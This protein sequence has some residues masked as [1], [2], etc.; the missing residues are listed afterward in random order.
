ML[1]KQELFVCMDV[2]VDVFVRISDFNRQQKKNKGVREEILLFPLLR[3][4]TSQLLI[5]DAETGMLIQYSIFC[6]G[7]FQRGEMDN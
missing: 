7:H 2:L 5:T 1:R 4:P 6:S 3:K